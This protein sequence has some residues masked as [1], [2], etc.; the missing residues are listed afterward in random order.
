MY[1]ASLYN[2]DKVNQKLLAFVESFQ[3]N[4]FY[5]FI[6]DFKHFETIIQRSFDVNNLKEIAEFFKKQ[7]NIFGP[8]F[9]LLFYRI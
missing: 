8:H 3:L 5:D 4:V 2:K 9:I 6:L 1:D 7:I